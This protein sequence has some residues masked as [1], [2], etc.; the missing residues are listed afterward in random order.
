VRNPEISMAENCAQPGL[1]NPRR[2]AGGAGRGVGRSDV[3]WHVCAVR[4]SI[5][6]VRLMATVAISRRIAGRVV[7]ADVAVGA[8]I[9]HRPDGAGDGGARRE[10]M[11]A[12]KREARSAVV[13]LSIGP[14][15]SVVAAR[16]ERGRKARRDVVGDVTAEG[17]RAIPGGLMAAVAIGVGR[18][19]IVVVSDVTIRAE[20]HFSC[21]SELVRTCQRPAGHGMVEDHIRPK[22]GVVTC[23]A[24]GSGKWCAS[25]GVRGVVRLLPGRQMALRIPA[26][27]RL[28]GKGGVVAVVALVAASDLS[29]GRNL[30]R[31]RQRKSRGGVIERRIGPHNRVV[32]L[33]TERR[34]K[35]AVIWFGTPPPNEGVLF[36]AVW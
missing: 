3:I 26:I 9:D 28:D 36:Q 7:A 22:R 23:G 34:G 1:R 5:R 21:R 33:R 18:G 4:L 35:P 6:E 10:H 30:M 31:V 15:Q 2:M 11:R 29:G 14:Q 17:R 12:L 19:E 16:T 32:A 20:V 27:G 24:I 13:K 8:G 25:G